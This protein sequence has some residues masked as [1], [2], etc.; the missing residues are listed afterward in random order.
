V[1]TALQFLFALE[2]KSKGNNIVVRL[3]RLGN[4]SLVSEAIQLLRT[5]FVV[6]KFSEEEESHL[7]NQVYLSKV[8][9]KKV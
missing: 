2:L 9:K 1:T 7:F 3:F 4:F 6:F 5:T 8:L